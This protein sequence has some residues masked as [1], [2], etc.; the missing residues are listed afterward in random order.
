MPKLDGED[1]F[2]VIKNERP[3]MKVIIS[4]VYTVDEQKLH[5]FDADDYY[6]KA[7]G[8]SVLLSKVHALI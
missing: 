6:N 2:E 7:D 5:V 4:S 8:L 3:A 1:V